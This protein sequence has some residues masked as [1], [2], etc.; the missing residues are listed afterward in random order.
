MRMIDQAVALPEADAG[1]IVMVG[2]SGGGM[3]TTYAAA[4]DTRVTVAVPSCSFATYVGE[5]GT[6]H[7]CE[8][9]T[10]PGIYRFGEFSD[11]AGLP[12]VRAAALHAAPGAPR[13]PSSWWDAAAPRDA[14]GERSS[15][16]W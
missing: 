6:V 5:S 13:E 9:N 10:V 8:C 7:H 2:N 3:V 14:M 15:R 16:C 12:G 1:R 11:V 4:C